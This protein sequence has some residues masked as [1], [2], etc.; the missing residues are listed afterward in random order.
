MLNVKG[1]NMSAKKD[2][3][4]TFLKNLNQ[5]KMKRILFSIISLSMLSNISFAQCNDLFISE[6]VEG[7]GNNKAIE[8][9]NPTANAVSLANYRLIRHDNGNSN[10]LEPI[11]PQHVLN[12]PANISMAPK[13]VYVMALNL[14]DPNGT[15][16]SAPIDLELQAVAD[17]LLCNGCATTVGNSRVLCFNGDDALALQKNVGGSWVNIDIF[18]CIGEQPTNNNGTASPTAGWTILPPFSSMPVG[19]TPPGAYFLEYW[20][21]DKTLFRKYAIGNGVTTNPAVASFNPSLQWDSLPV[22]TFDGLGHHE[23]VCGCTDFTSATVNFT[24]NLETCAGSTTAVSATLLGIPGTANF[25]YLW[26]NGATSQNTTLGVGT[27]SV[28]ITKDGQCSKTATVTIVAFATPTATQI[29][30]APATCGAQNGAVSIAL[31]GG[32]GPFQYSWP[33]NSSTND[34]L[35]NVGAGSYQ[36]QITDAKNCTYTFFGDVQDPGAP[37]ITI[38]NVTS[39]TC[40]TCQNGAISVTTTASASATYSWTFNGTVYSTNQDLTNLNP[41]V[42][43]LTLLDNGCSASV[44]VNIPNT[45]GISEIFNPLTINVSPNPSNKD[46]TLNSNDIIKIVRIFSVTGSQEK[47]VFAHQSNQS[48]NIDISELA[49]GLHIAQIFDSKGNS[50]SIKFIKQ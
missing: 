16:Q 5:K 20:T 24:G 27:H 28:T 49:N 4:C 14:T 26:S 9:F 23:C 39:A 11:D 37:T 43:T 45:V 22:N 46:I 34:T 31:T 12:L 47:E 30:I 17:T 36:C 44:A 33:I 13:T 2:Y 6:Y 48:I 10:T 18:A 50:R 3:I 1:V 15:G 21:Q 19:F 29:A 38:D 7:S 40:G 41:G 42:Y 8:I 32:F 35:F 25:T